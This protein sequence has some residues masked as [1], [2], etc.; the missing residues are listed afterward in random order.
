MIPNLSTPYG[1]SLEVLNCYLKSL[2][3]ANW[4]DPHGTIRIGST[5][6]LAEL[7]RSKI[8]LNASIF[9]NALLEDDGAPMT[10][11]GNLTRAFARRMFDAMHF[12]PGYRERKLYVCKVLNEPDVRNLPE[13]RVLAEYG[14]LMVRRNE[15]FVITKLGREL[16]ADERAGELFRRL[17]LT[18]FRTMELSCMV[19]VRE[20][21]E[22]QATLAVTLWR[23]EQ[24][25]ENWRGVKGMAAQILPPRVLKHIVSQQRG[26]FDTPDYF[27]AAYVLQPLR[28]FGLLESQRE[29]E[30]HVGVKDTVRVTPLFRRFI[31]FA[32]IPSPMNN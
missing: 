17:F 12:E 24:V 4:E 1:V 23:L 30:W 10:V 25:A 2:Y 14:K 18:F 6:T 13:I 19:Y 20:V 28:D 8:F 9:L 31:G 11:R 27:V 32:E 3:D 7:A 29:G 5:I 21:P 16:L 26:D 22:I 15:R